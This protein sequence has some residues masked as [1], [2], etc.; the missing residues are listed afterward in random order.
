MLSFEPA[1]KRSVKIADA[2][3]KTTGEKFQ[4]WFNPIYGS[5]DS[6]VEIDDKMPV[7]LS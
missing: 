6:L 1:V 3:N 5:K 4:I 2:H 7:L